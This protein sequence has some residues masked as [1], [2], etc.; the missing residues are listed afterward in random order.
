M[1]FLKTQFQ[2][3]PQ[4]LSFLRNF[5]T[6]DDFNHYLFLYVSRCQESLRPSPNSVTLGGLIRLSIS[7]YFWLKFVTVKGYKQNKQIERR[8]GQSLEGT[9]KIP[10]LL[11]SHRTCLIPLATGVSS[12]VKSLPEWFIIDSAP[13]IFYWDQSC[14]YPLCRYPL[15]SMYQNSRL[16]E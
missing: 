13:R 8:T 3:S 2:S 9:S 7:P 11:V 6:T 14:R 12:H 5:I 4:P 16:Q 10:L 15:P 1:W